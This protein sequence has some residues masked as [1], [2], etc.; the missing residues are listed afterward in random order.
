MTTRREALG[1]IGLALPAC[2]YAVRPRLEQESPAVPVGDPAIKVI[3]N[4]WIPMRDGSRLAARLFLP[5]A[6]SQAP[7]GAVL[8]YLPYRKRDAYRYRDDVAGPFLA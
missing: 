5:Q 3:E 2:A 6:A 4:V 8:E 1:L 7:T